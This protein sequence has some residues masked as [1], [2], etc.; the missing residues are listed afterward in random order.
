MRAGHTGRRERSEL[1]GNGGEEYLEELALDF[2]NIHASILRRFS[3]EKSTTC[4]SEG[5][6]AQT[7]TWKEKPLKGEATMSTPL[8]DMQVLFDIERSSYRYFGVPV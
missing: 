5:R 7:L 8:V 6:C 4:D 1:L 2:L 3:L